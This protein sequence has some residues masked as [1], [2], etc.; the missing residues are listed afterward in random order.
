M[1]WQMTLGERVK[2]K[3][4]TISR[5]IVL[6]G[7]KLFTLSFSFYFEVKYVYAKQFYSI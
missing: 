7:K 1:A 4:K 5:K 6:A 2:K 3:K